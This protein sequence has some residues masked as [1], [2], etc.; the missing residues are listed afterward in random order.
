MPFRKIGRDVVIWPWAKI[1]RPEAIEIG[2][3]VII[4][5]FVFLAGGEATT[6]GSFVHIAA[7][8]LITGGGRF[9]MEDFAGLS[10]GVRIYTGNED[11]LG[12]CLTNP[13]VPAPYRVP[14]R[15]QVVL[16][17]HAIVGA[18]AI[19]L[20]GVE[21]GEGAV[22]GAASLVKGDCA[23]WTIYAGVPA[24]PIKTRPRERILELEQQLRKELYDS[25]GR[26]IGRSR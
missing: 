23:P 5:D 14:I 25:A 18:N 24:R 17:R 20:P 15:S 16:R 1:V 10:G 6:L 4:D 13:A 22:V 19:I 2:D 26:Y 9:L 11:Y 8:T 7:H 3:S 12:G 21:I